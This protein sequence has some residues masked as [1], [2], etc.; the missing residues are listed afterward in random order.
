MANANSTL[1][2]TFTISSTDMTSDT[3]SFTVSETLTLTGSGGVKR[4]NIPV[5]YTGSAATGNHSLQYNILG[6]DTI[7]TKVGYEVYAGSGSANAT[8][9]QG[10]TGS[11]SHPP[12]YL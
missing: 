5:K 6:D 1:S 3:L 9:P 4:I 2:T 8:L 10:V 11:Q 7:D 12:R